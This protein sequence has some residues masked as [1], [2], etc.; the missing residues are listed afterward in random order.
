MD[1]E[2]R[3]HTLLALPT[4]LLVYIISLVTSLRERVKLRYVSRRLQCACETPSLWREFVWPYYHTEDEGCVNSV[5]KVCGEHV[6]QLSFP[7]MKMPTSQLLSTMAYCCNTVSLRLPSTA[8][9]SE[10]LDDIFTCMGHLQTLDIRW[11]RRMEQLLE[12]INH[13]CIDMKEL[14]I[15]DSFMIHASYRS[16]RH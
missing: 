6:K 4:K 12:A 7:D 11:D 5:L 2:H 9:N 8:L 14:T 1:H 15:R 3:S 13:K 16:W 10:L